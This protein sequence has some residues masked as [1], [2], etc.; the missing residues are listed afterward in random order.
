MSQSVRAFPTFYSPLGFQKLT[1]SSSAVGFTF[2]SV[3]IPIRAVHLTVENADARYKVD[4]NSPTSTDGERL[5]DGDAVEL[6][7]VD[8]IKNFKAIAVSTDALFQI[9]YFGGE[10]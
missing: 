8:M 4:G 6:T 2:P 9:H 7:N 10:F 5:Y 1:V 3:S